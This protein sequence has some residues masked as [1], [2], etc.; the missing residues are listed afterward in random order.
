MYLVYWKILTTLIKPTVL[1]TCFKFLSVW[2]QF[3]YTG[4]FLPCIFLIWLYALSLFN[5]KFKT[6][7]VLKLHLFWC[8]YFGKCQKNWGYYFEC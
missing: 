8:S 7:N 5:L 6:Y 2:V 3:G 4:V 1:Y